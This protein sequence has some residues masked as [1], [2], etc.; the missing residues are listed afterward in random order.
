M[1][2][3]DEEMTGALRQDMNYLNDR[4]KVDKSFDLIYRT[5]EIGGREA[6]MYFIDGFCKD[7]LM[8]KSCS[9]SSASRQKLCRRM[10]IKCVS[11]ACP[12]WRWTLAESG[13]TS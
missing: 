10:P 4:L 5:I 7:E 12:M 6:C 9:I 1:E 13:T 3:K 8:E 11:S 2:K